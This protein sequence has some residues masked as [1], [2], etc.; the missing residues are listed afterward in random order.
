MADL[1]NTIKKAGVGAMQANAPVAV[2]FGTVT[3]ADPLEI[4]IEQKM[5][6]TAAFLVLT[7]AVKD[8]GV[9]FTV[10]GSTG[11]GG[12]PGHYH[13]YS[14]DKLYLQQSTLR[15]GDTVVLL[16]VQGGQK[17]VVLDRVWST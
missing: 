12:D 3:S 6:L 17:F 9:T 13:D 10:N 16:R 5:T 11:S 2:M 4:K 14:G 15:L 1:L 8:H 7:D